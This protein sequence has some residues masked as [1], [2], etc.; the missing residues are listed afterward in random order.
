VGGP[1]G[2]WL[3]AIGG[4]TFNGTTRILGGRGFDHGYDD[5]SNTVNGPFTRAGLDGTNAPPNLQNC[6]GKLLAID[7]LH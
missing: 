7:C 4:N 1:E 6:I 2:D 3:A 5:G